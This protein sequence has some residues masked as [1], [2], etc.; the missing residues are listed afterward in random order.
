MWIS[1][2]QIEIPARLDWRRNAGHVLDQRLLFHT[3]FLDWRIAEFRSKIH[4]S[5]RY[6]GLRIRAD[7]RRT[8]D[9]EQARRRHLRLGSLLGR[10]S[11]ESRDLRSGRVAT[12]SAFRLVACG[13]CF[14]SFWNFPLFTQQI[15]VFCFPVWFQ[16]CYVCNFNL[17]C[18]FG[19]NPA[20][21]TSSKRSRVTLARF[22]RQVPDEACCQQQ[23]TRQTTF[24]ASN[25]R[26]TSSSLTGLTVALQRFVNWMTRISGLNSLSSFVLHSLFRLESSESV[27][28]LQ[29]RVCFPN[30]LLLFSIFVFCCSSFTYYTIYIPMWTQR[31]F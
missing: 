24:W 9:T 22:T 27:L 3:V 2:L 5:N 14:N 21:R 20:L 4:D 15:S 29:L 7:A 23:V 16:H 13:T 17:S 28:S 30:S 8:R 1:S 18:R 31:K 25:C 26:R 11:V 6:A 10:S 19:W 12:E